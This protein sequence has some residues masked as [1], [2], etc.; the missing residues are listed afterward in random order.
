M[1]SF[2]PMVTPAFRSISAFIAPF[3]DTKGGALLAAFGIP[4]EGWA[5][6]INL[7]FNTGSHTAAS[8][9]VLNTPIPGSLLLLG[10][11]IM[12]LVGIGVR[13]KSA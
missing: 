1:L 10:S 12:S 11:G 7:S 6:L 9:D 4:A 5:G 3:D 8:G 2:A 13:R